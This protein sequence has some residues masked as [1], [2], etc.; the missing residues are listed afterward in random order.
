MNRTLYDCWN[1]LLV[2]LRL[3]KEIQKTNALNNAQNEQQRQ[4][5]ELQSKMVDE[6]LDSTKRSLDN[7]FNNNK[8]TK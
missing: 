2:V 5:I 3:K 4:I 7:E 6:V 8:D 1:T